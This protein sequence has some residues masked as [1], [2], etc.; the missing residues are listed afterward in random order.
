M[1][2]ALPSPTNETPIKN[3]AAVMDA[4]WPLVAE[5]GWHGFSFSDLATRSGLDLAEL[6]QS[7]PAKFE[8]LRL[9][10]RLVDQAV[11]ENSPVTSTGSAR[12]RLFDTLMRRLDALQPHRLGLLRFYRDLRSDP[13]L[14]LAMTPIIAASMAWMLEASN[15]NA[16]G[17]AGLLRVNG[18]SV[19]WL[20][21]LREWEQDDSVDLGSTM[22]ALD[23]ALDKAE[24]VA[25]TFRMGEEDAAGVEQRL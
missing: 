23:R 2:D 9:H 12:D 24:R 16:C 20:S 19:V 11:L 18:L 22:A 25:N 5:R 13:L 17:P 15:I 3:E 8:L 1:S 7:F 14:T 6:R 4:L 21:T 10:A